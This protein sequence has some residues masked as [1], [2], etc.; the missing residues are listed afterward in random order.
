MLLSKNKRSGIDA[1]AEEHLDMTAMVD[2]VFQLMT[3]LLLT[4]QASTE[5]AVKMP[6]A[7]YGVGI[8]DVDTVV[9]IVAPPPQAGAPSPVYEGLDIDPRRQLADSDAITAAVET[10]LTAGKRRVIIQADGDVA[11]GE[12]L[13]VA[14][15]AAKVQGISIHIGVEEPQN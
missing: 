13:R 15:A 1:E 5:A 4:Y 7:K 11:H 3:F 9:L 10:G 8:E 14:A 12:V 6:Q 2:V